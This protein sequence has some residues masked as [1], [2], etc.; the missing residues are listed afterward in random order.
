MLAVI[1]GYM[2][3]AVSAVLLFQMS[4]IDTPQR[5]VDGCSFSYHYLRHRFLI[6]R[7]T[8]GAAYFGIS[9]IDC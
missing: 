8:F 6:R 4:G 1:L 7:G 3:F 5:S 9:Q 2:I